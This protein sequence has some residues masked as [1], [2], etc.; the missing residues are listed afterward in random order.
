MIKTQKLKYRDNNTILEGFYAYDDSHTNKRPAVL[1]AHDWSGRNEFA[2]KKAIMLAELGYV[3]FAID[4][5]GEGK[6]GQSTD[7][8]KALIAPLLHNRETLFQ[9]INS[10][11]TFLKTLDFVDVKKM[12]AIGFCF[13]GLCV[14]D[15]ARHSVDINGVVSFHGLLN[16]PPSFEM[17][18]PLSP[19]IL[20]LHGHDD[21]MVTPED[22]LTF[23]KE[24]TKVKADWQVNIY[25]NTKHAFTN[26]QANDEHLGTIYNKE[27]AQR[28]LLAMQNFFSEIFR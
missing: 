23:E 20:V 18:A 25:S 26:P 10:A 12:G 4:M 14:L 28:S 2:D 1:V 13:G 11:F 15:L 17:K 5:Y 16:P 9:R 27:S 22:V 24:M 7:E 8:K 6:I 3:G 19:K 21:P